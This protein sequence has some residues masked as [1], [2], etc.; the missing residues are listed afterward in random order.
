MDSDTRQRVL[1][2]DDNVELLELLV[3][4][5]SRMGGFDVMGAPDGVSGLRDYFEFRPDCV[6]IDVKIP[7]LD[8]YQLVRALRGDPASAETPLIILSALAQERNRIAGLLS[9]AD[10]YLAKPVTPQ[11]LVTNI[12]EAIEI[13][14]TG[15]TERLETLLGQ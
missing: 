4:S 2:V 9:G 11:E 15:R 7:A 13:G 8:G 12:R 10:R 3:S 5:L 6:V 1:I 14:A